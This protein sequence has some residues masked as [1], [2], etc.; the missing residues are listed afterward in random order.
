MC[1]CS[2][3]GIPPRSVYGDVPLVSVLK[4]ECGFSLSCPRH[5]YAGGC[6]LSIDSYCRAINLYNRETYSQHEL[7]CFKWMPWKTLADCFCPRL[8]PY[9]TICNSSIGAL[10]L[11]LP[12]RAR[13][14]QASMVPW[15]IPFTSKHKLFVNA[16]LSL[17]LASKWVLLRI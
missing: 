1:A 4:P 12:L 13:L 8:V 2:L 7:I 9:G 16:P 14:C 10:L 15:V 3:A 5:T 6:L 17:N 11:A